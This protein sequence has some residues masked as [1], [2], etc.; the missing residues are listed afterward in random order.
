[1]SEI[2]QRD[3]KE[4]TSGALVSVTIARVSPDLGSVKYYLSIFPNERAS[5][6]IAQLK[7]HNTRLRYAL[8]QRVG[9]Q[10]RV[11]PEPHFFLDDSLDYLENID[12]LLKD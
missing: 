1:M 12:R 3:L 5:E 10:L 9:K 4:L 8:G 7:E 2:L 11:T 6:V